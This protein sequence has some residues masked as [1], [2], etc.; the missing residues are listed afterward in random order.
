MG[1]LRPLSLGRRGHRRVFMRDLVSGDA[2]GRCSG[3]LR[4]WS[5]SQDVWC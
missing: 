3:G 1:R 4:C 5:V 2:V